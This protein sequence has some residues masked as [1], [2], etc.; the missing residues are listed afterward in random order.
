M[1]C[2]L[3]EC[4]SISKNGGEIPRRLVDQGLLTSPKSATTDLLYVHYSGISSFGEY[5]PLYYHS[6]KKPPISQNTL[7]SEY[8]TN[9]R[10]IAVL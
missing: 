6:E 9:C 10:S 2:I 8:E 7:K 3:V 1:H 4:T 5:L